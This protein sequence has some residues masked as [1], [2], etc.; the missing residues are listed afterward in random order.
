[1]RRFFSVPAVAVVASI[2]AACAERPSVPH[3]P[4]PGSLAPALDQVARPA[5]PPPADTSN[6]VGRNAREVADLLGAPHF[7][8]RDPPAELWQYR[9]EPCVL[10][11]FL[12]ADKAGVNFT[13]TH[14]EM[15]AGKTEASRAECLRAVRNASGRG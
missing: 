3:A 8:R 11:V 1:M 14:V 4:A 6:L 13:V 15:R 10:D 5:T 9:A 2:A 12:Y 7:K